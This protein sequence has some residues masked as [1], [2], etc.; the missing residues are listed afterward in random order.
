MKG[1]LY[2]AEQTDCQPAVVFKAKRTIMPGEELTISYYP[3]DMCVSPFFR[4]LTGK[5]IDSFP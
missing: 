3:E 2:G 5:F 4:V 1:A